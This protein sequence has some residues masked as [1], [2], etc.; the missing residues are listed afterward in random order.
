VKP[1]APGDASIEVKNTIVYLG[2]LGTSQASAVVP[3]VCLASGGVDPV[4]VR[5][6]ADV[7][8]FDP[9]FHSCLA[10]VQ[11]QV[12]GPGFTGISEE[13]MYRDT[14]GRPCGPLCWA[15]P[16]GVGAPLQWRALGA[17]GFG[18]AKWSGG[19]Q[20]TSVRSESECLD[21]SCCRDDSCNPI[22]FEVTRDLMCLAEFAPAVRV[23]SASFGSGSCGTPL[24]NATTALA[25]ECDGRI[26]CP[27][28][29]TTRILGDPAVGCPKDFEAEWQ[30]GS[31]ASVKSVSHEAVS[32]EGYAVELSCK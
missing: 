3:V 17:P 5:C 13:L 32:S 8:F 7:S 19:C 14:L 11:L 29:V 20:S 10:K 6:P 31:D 18:L 2:R 24:G 12:V 15:Y 21:E 28:V 26:H 30:C 4:E 25:R 27:I 22:I 16:P 23:L 9:E 1:L